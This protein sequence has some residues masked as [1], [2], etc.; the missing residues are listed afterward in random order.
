VAIAMQIAKMGIVIIK[1]AIP[2][3]QNSF[4]TFVT[5][6]IT[7]TPI[8]HASHRWAIFRHILFVR[9]RARDGHGSGGSERS[10]LPHKSDTP[11]SLKFGPVV[12][13][14]GVFL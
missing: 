11:S 12:L 9:S 5:I 3:P 10:A 8:R 14:I 4:G 7:V 13:L 2:L 6:E 1:A